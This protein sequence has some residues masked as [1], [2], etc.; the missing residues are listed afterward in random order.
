MFNIYVKLNVDKI[1]LKKNEC[2]SKDL[3]LYF[4]W[5]FYLTHIE[6]ASVN[7]V[8]LSRAQNQKSGNLRNRD[9]Y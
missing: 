2:N 6:S 3:H 8:K 1:I 9:Q 7:F 5:L 4:S